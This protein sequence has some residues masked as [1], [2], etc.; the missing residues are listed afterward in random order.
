MIYCAAMRGGSDMSEAKQAGDRAL[1][2]ARRNLI[3]GV[4][5]ISSFWGLSKAMGELYGLLYLSPG[6]M[7]LDEMAGALG[8]SKAS[9]STHI[10]ALER[11]GMV[12]KEW[13]VGDRRDY[14]RAEIDFWAIAKGILRQREARE[15]DQALNSVTDSLEMVRGAGSGADEEMAQ[16]YLER[17]KHMQEF[18]RTLDTLV[19]AA[20]TLDELRLASLARLGR[21]AKEGDEG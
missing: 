6:A 14:Y 16:F 17:L 3:Q 13:R 15:F 8:I 5:R 20:L 12:R 4:G 11:L 10:R 2:G 21:L 18:F 1:E 9:V 19:R 7:S